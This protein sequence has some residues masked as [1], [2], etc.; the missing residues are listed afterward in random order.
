MA[1]QLTP[2]LTGAYGHPVVQTPHL[3]RLVEGGIRFDAAYSSYPLCAP[4]RASLMTGQ[5]GSRIGAYDN[6]AP[7]ASDQPCITH[8]LSNAGYEAIASG[9]LHYVGPDQLH[10]F[11]RRLTTDCYPSTFDWCRPDRRP[12]AGQP[13]PSRQFAHNYRLPGV[14]VRAWPALMSYDEEAQF[15]ALEYLYS[16]QPAEGGDRTE[17][18]FLCLSFHAPH[19]P[20]HVTQEL[21]DLYE[22][23]PIEIP[24]YPADIE[25]TYST[26]DRWLNTYHATDRIDIVDPDSLRALRRSYYGRVSYVD[27]Q[28][29][30]ILLALERTGLNENTVIMFTSDHG[31]MIAEK[32]MVQKRSFYEWSCRVPLIVTFSDGWQ[33]GKQCAQPVSLVDL[34]PTVLELAGVRDWLPI[35]GQSLLPTIEGQSDDERV[36]YAE[37]H[38]EGVYAPCFMARKGRSKYVYI[39]GHDAQLFDLE[40]DPGEWHN[41]V[42][43]PRFEAVQAELETSI[44][45][46]FDPDAIEQDLRESHQRRL[47]IKEAMQANDV[48]W[49]YFPYFDARKR[50]ARRGTT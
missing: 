41:L 7:L 28:V 33:A 25:G 31:D 21:W 22:G 11:R 24:T 19:E 50:R 23:Q 49:D 6:S 29:G 40:T 45:A 42:G 4:A 44:L 35:D 26:M 12:E 47:V 39:H 27:E 34:L 17:P 1:D 14:G 10:G 15:R 5:Y 18:F 43:D 20:F 8:Y 37:N 9:K 13:L 32:N 16:R 36:I 48:Y 46:Q 3:D 2:F 38:V 30:K